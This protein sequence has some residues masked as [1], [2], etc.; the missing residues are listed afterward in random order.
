MQDIQQKIK[1]YL[2]DRNW[3]DLPPADFAKSVSIEAAELLEI[4]QW[5]NPTISETLENSD[6][7]KEIKGELA[8]VMIYCLD[9][10]AVLDIDAQQIILDKLDHNSKKYPAEQM[11]TPEGDAD[12]WKIKA[13]HR[14]NRT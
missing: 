13:E 3:A 9:L 4:F 1:K 7:M 11:K 10:C 8:D 6:K 2:I 14:K 12:Y 5:D